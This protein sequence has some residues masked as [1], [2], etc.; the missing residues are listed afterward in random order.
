[1]KQ[2]VYLAL[3]SVFTVN[4]AVL[5]SSGTAGSGAVASDAASSALVTEEEFMSAWKAGMQIVDPNTPNTPHPTHAQYMAMANGAGSAGG[6]TSRQELAMFFAQIMHQSSGLVFKKE[7]NPKLGTNGVGAPGKEYYGRG[8]IQ[9]AWPDN[10]K[11]A[12]EALFGPGNTSLYDDPDQVATNEDLAW[13]VSFFYWK[14]MVKPNMTATPDAFGLSTRAINGPN[15]CDGKNTPIAQKR[16]N[17]YTAVLKAW[18][19]SMTPVE[20]GCYN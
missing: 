3:L 17:I 16:Y 10:Y 12:S 20:S 5:P 4:A 6:I 15:E 8:Y 18:E 11:K 13:G 9:L 14:S 1:M 7:T 2:F 19:P